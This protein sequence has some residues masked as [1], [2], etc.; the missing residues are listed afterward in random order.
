MKVQL[1]E[2]EIMGECLANIIT[3]RSLPEAMTVVAAL[4]C[5]AIEATDLEASNFK[6]SDEAFDSFFSKTKDIYKE[7]Q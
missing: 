1:S 7:A 2:E 4:V 3:Q 6:N 5:T